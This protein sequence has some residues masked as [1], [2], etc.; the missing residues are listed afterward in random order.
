LGN[1]RAMKLSEAQ[2]IQQLRPL[3]N[4]ELPIDWDPFSNIEDDK[5]LHRWVNNPDNNWC[6][7]KKHDFVVLTDETEYTTGQYAR[8]VLLILGITVKCSD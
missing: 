2:A 4:E 5:Y 6:S 7:G 1:Y 3:L 8:T